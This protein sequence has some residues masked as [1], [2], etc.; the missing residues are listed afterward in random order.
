MNFSQFQLDLKER[1]TEAHRNAE[2]HPFMQSMIAGTHKKEQLLQFLVNILPIYTV[3]EERLL[4]EKINTVPD[5]R[6]SLLIENDI[7]VLVQELNVPKTS[8]LLTPLLCARAWINNCWAKPTSLLKAEL[9][10]RWLADFYGGRMLAKTVTPSAMYSSEN[11]KQVIETVRAVLDEPNENNITNEDIIQ[12]IIS[13][14]NLH[15]ELF[16]EIYNGNS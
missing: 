11:P 4:G 13:F 16:D 10:S 8:P 12:E 7:N 9:Y 3:V 2:S 1:T 15:I 5:L 14:F 6:R